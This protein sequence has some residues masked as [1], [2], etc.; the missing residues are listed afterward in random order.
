MKKKKITLQKLNL[1]KDT[2]SLLTEDHQARINGG[3]PI[4]VGQEWCPG[5][6]TRNQTENS[7]APGCA[8]CVRYSYV[9]VCNTLVG[10]GG[11]CN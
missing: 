2:I 7:A 4:S 5:G 10:P 3:G 11:N 1:N 9:P 8:C 6:P